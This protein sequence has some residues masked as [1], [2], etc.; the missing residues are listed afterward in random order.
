MKITYREVGGQNT[1]VIKGAIKAERCCYDVEL[2]WQVIVIDVDLRCCV[3]LGLRWIF[4]VKL[5]EEDF[6]RAGVEPL[7]MELIN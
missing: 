7:F 3:S 5:I 1:Q 6:V 2:K 4:C